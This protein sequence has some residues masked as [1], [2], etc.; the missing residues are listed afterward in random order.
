M[1][2][3]TNYV[4]KIIHK[5]SDNSYSILTYIDIDEIITEEY[6][7]N[8]INEIISN[9]QIL[10]QTIIENGDT[11]F[12]NKIIIPN[13]NE[14]YKIDYTKTENFDD[15]INDLL[16]KDF[17]SELKWE[18][19]W[20]ID[21]DNKKTR[22]YFKIHHA[23]VDGYQLIKILTSPF[24]ND[25]ITKQFKR[26]TDTYS[27][28]YYYLVGTV[29]LI[30]INI[31][32]FINILLNNL[33]LWFSKVEATSKNKEYTDYLLCKKMDLSEIKKFTKKYKITINDFLYSLMIKTDKL[34]RRDAKML[35]TS[36]PINISG[37]TQ[38]NNLCP[39][40]N[41]I[42][43]SYDNY[44][45]LNKVH[46]I[47]NNFKY[48]LFIPFLSAIINIAMKYIR[49]DVLLTYYNNVL[50]NTDYTYSNIIG[51]SIK[52]VKIKITDIH[53]LTTSKC[54]EIVYN[55]ISCDNN[56]NI[57]CSFKKNVIEDK[58]R[59]EKCIYEAYD[60]LITTSD[61]Y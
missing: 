53:F 20:C 58:S 29:I 56:I 49:L 42:D 6:I 34:Y 3:L 16:N 21:K 37:T 44:T 43:N 14:Y 46:G 40:F 11:L 50:T 4:S 26:T 31:K 28:I 30:I 59:F 45:L 19:L 35:S 8:Y 39:I 9:N 23:Y 24:Q 32:F 54:K 2:E 52:D 12:L 48:S 47:F 5:D 10:T 41:I 36:S 60:S 7:I 51:P 61:Y 25:D 1:I 18:C 15:Y 55:I 38:I 13:I 27:T 22:F 57:I 17:N 33:Y